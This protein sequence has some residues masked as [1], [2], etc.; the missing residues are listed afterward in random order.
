MPPMMLVA[1]L[2]WP[3]VLGSGLYLGWRYVRA[4]E[5]R[6]VAEGELTSLRER[7]LQIEEGLDATRSDVARLETGHEF[8]QRLLNERAAI[9]PLAT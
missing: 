9:T 6:S 3:V 8:T 5:R 2:F 7:M 1:L 4:V